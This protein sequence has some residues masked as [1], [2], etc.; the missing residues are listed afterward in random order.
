MHC[1]IKLDVSCTVDDEVDFALQNFRICCRQAQARLGQI[2]LYCLD[3]FESITPA[4]AGLLM[5]S[6]KQ[7][8]TKQLLDTL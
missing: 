4:V 2:A 5:K 6:M 7:R 1:G 3:P 8:V